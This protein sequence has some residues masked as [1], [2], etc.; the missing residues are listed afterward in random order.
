MPDLKP[1]EIEKMLLEIME[2]KEKLAN[3]KETLKSYKIKSERLTE[4]KK[5]KKGLN[6]QIEEE[7][8]NIED[9]FL[10]DKDYEQA[11]NDDLTLRNQIKEKNTHLRKAMAQ[12]NREQDLSTYSYN[13]KGEPIKMQVERVVKVYI[14]GREEK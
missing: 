13:I 12:I 4:L 6:E 1:N 5:A 11:S 8:K 10:D 7:K 14:N 2:L 3:A 9:E